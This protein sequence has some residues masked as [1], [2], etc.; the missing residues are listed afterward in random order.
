[1]HVD[2]VP[3]RTHE[4]TVGVSVYFLRQTRVFTR[5]AEEGGEADSK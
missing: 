1:M 4:N 3:L 2:G 5:E